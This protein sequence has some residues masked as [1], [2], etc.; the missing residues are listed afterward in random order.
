MAIYSLLRDRN[1][2]ADKQNLVKV[3][4]QIY[5]QHIIF[6]TYDF[7]KKVYNIIPYLQLSLFLISFII[8]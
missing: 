2:S 7:F 4:A 6:T 5:I 8:H 3:Q 1:I